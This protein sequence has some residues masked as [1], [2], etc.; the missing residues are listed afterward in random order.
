MTKLFFDSLIQHQQLSDAISD[1]ADEDGVCRLSQTELGNIVGRSQIWVSQAIKRIN[2]EEICIVCQNGGYRTL[3][4]KLV[5][6]GVFATLL[7]LCGEVSRDREVFF[8][9]DAEL[10][11][12]Y[13]VP[14]KTVQM[15]KSYFRTGHRVASMGKEKNDVHGK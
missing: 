1:F 10:A 3:Y 4:P 12:K 15:L 8:L 7:F 2:S 11:R 6:H 9:K 14:L 13:D 5:D